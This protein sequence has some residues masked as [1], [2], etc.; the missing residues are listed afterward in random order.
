MKMTE[1]YNRTYEN[2]KQSTKASVLLYF[3][4]NFGEVRTHGL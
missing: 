4:S 2:E 1:V 3:S